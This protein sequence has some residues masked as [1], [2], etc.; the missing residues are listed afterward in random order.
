MGGRGAYQIAGRRPPGNHK[1]VV[2]T[3]CAGAGTNA[4]CCSCTGRRLELFRAQF[5]ACTHPSGLERWDGITLG[6][7]GARRSSCPCSI[8]HGRFELEHAHPACSKRI[9]RPVVMVTARPKRRFVFSAGVAQRQC[10]AFTIVRLIR[11][12]RCEMSRRVAS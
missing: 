7:C 5:R 12:L 6:E 8:R 3:S 11:E 2:T 1:L 9:A 4:V 10:S